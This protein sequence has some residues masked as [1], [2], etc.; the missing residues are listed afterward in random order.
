LRIA[1][2]AAAAAIESSEPSVP[3]TRVFMGSGYQ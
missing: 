2:P 1:K 3:T